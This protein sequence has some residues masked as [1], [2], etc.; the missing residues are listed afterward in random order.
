MVLHLY[1][2]SST[3][4]EPLLSLRRW[5]IFWHCHQL[6]AF[7]QAPIRPSQ[8]SARLPAV[9]LLRN[10]TFLKHV[11]QMSWISLYNYHQEKAGYFPRFLLVPSRL[12]H[13]RQRYH[14]STAPWQLRLRVAAGFNAKFIFLII[15]LFFL[16]GSQFR[17]SLLAL[18]SSCI[19]PE[20]LLTAL[21]SIGVSIRQ[22]PLLLRIGTSK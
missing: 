17:M 15:F 11:F 1:Y 5:C 6:R 12:L 13:G 7:L 22:S 10:N 4:L 20:C 9:L 3:H 18:S 21:I 16:C 8:F 19:C 14:S 2:L